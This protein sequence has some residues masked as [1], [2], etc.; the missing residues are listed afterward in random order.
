MIKVHLTCQMLVIKCFLSFF[1]RFPVLASELGKGTIV[2]IT[3]QL[4]VREMGERAKRLIVLVKFV[5]V[6]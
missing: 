6:E 3:T 1:P 4:W 2:I 5:H